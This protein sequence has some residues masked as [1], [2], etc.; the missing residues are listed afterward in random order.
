MEPEWNNTPEMEDA[1]KLG[2]RN[3][4]MQ[5]L[6]KYNTMNFGWLKNRYWD[7][8]LSINKRSCYISGEN[9]QFK[10]AYRGRK[11]IRTIFSGN[12]VI[13]DDV[14]I[15]QKAYSDLILLNKIA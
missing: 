10:F 13:Y 1:I 4:T 3:K 15:S 2:L 7:L 12:K 6:T 11:P 8:K 9:I 14:W 5:K